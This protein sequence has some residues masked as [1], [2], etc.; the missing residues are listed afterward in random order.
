MT[1]RATTEP[2]TSKRVDPELVEKKL[3]RLPTFPRYDSTRLPVKEGTEECR[4]WN[5]GEVEATRVRHTIEADDG[6]FIVVTGVPARKC[7]ICGETTFPGYACRVLDWIRFLTESDQDA[8][9]RNYSEEAERFRP[10]AERESLVAEETD[11]FRGLDKEEKKKAK[12]E[13]KEAA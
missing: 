13:A 2:A 1:E 11:D 10:I 8:V 6:T 7:T 5:I 12:K 3:S 9:V 4:N